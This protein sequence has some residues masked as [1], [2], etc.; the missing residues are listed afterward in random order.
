MMIMH[1]D[2]IYDSNVVAVQNERL[3]GGHDLGYAY[4]P[5]EHTSWFPHDVTFGNVYSLG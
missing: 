3:S 4:V 1:P 5:R 2:N